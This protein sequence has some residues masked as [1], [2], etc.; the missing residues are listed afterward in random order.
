MSLSLWII[1]ALWL[2]IFMMLAFENLDGVRGLD[3][4]SLFFALFI[5][6]IG[7]PFF[8]VTNILEYILNYILPDGWGNDDFFK[9]S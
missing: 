4:D 7:A 6:L 5:F 3:P 8:L 1:F 2:A 9:G